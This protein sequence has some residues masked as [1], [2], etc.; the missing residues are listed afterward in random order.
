M[1]IRFES[2]LAKQL[3]D[4]ILELNEAKTAQRV[5][6]SQIVVTEYTSSQ[7]STT[8]TSTGYFAEA[9]AYCIAEAPTITGNNVLL[10]HCVPEVRL[11]GT[12]IDNTAL[13]VYSYYVTNIRSDTGNKTIYQLTIYHSS[14]QG[15]T[16]PAET[17]TVKF[18]IHSA[19][20]VTLTVGSGTYE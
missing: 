9:Y 13:G 11:N 10:T 6:N 12:L 2:S 19:A 20:D 17:F 7:L 3:R 4:I 14:S 16:V 8:S 1:S 5:G 18:H 15:E